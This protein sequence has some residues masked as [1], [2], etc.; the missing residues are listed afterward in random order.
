MASFEGIFIT[1]NSD[2]LWGI[3]W[4]TR[5][6]K[7]K[8][9]TKLVKIKNKCL[10]PPWVLMIIWRMIESSIPTQHNTWH[11]NE[12]GSPLTNPSFHER[13][14][15]EMTPFWRSLVKGILRPQ[16]KLEVECRLQS[17]LKF[18]MF[19]KWRI[20]SFVPT[21]L[22]GSVRMTLTLLKWGLGSP[23]GILKT[24]WSITGVK[25]PRL[26]MFFIPLKRSWSLNVEN[27]L[28]WTIRISTM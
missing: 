3:V 5:V 12:S 13:C 19:P 9:Q 1:K 16:C 20:V 26:E 18:F 6:M 27:G 4:R 11:S 23:S 14:T 10:S 8:R 7:K 24:Q 17:S 2:I 21:P 28:I 22:W 25:T 15:W